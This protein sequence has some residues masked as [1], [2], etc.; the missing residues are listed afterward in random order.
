MLLDQPG[1]HV[2]LAVI[3]SVVAGRLESSDDNLCLKPSVLL[4]S[5]FAILITL[6]F[7]ITVE[8]D[9]RTN[10]SLRIRVETPERGK[11]SRLH[12]SPSSVSSRA[13]SILGGDRTDTR[14]LVDNSECDRLIFGEVVL[15]PLLVVRSLVFFSMTWY[16][17]GMG[18]L[19][20]ALRVDS[21]ALAGTAQSLSTLKYKGGQM[22]CLP[23]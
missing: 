15:L 8:A 22:D 4:A 17:G 13:R 9:V 3:I 19:V 1:C 7:L 16:N 10:F 23:D 14:V 5:E 18:Q 12:T 11:I 21:R 20:V 6:S 2:S